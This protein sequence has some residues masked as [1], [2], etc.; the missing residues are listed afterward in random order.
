MTT[1]CL[2]TGGRD[3]FKGRSVA[4]GPLAQY[5]AKFGDNT[6]IDFS[7]SWAHELEVENRM[8]GNAVFLSA[9]GKF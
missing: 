4:V 7:L 8:E 3:G 9:Y 1:V 2:R 5:T 6:E